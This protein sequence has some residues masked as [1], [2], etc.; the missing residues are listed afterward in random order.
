MACVTKKSQKNRT[1]CHKSTLSRD[2]YSKGAFLEEVV[3]G[4]TSAA[5][6]LSCIVE[7]RI[8]NEAKTIPKQI[9]SMLLTL[10][11]LLT[12]FPTA[13]FAEDTAADRPASA[14]FKIMGLYALRDN[15]RRVSFFSYESRDNA[16]LTKAN[17]TYPD[18]WFKLIYVIERSQ[19]VTLELYE[20]K[21]EPAYMDEDIVS[22]PYAPED[23]ADGHGKL[24]SEGVPWPP[25]R[26]TGGRSGAGKYRPASGGDDIYTAEQVSYS[27]ID[28]DEWLNIVYQ[29]IRGKRQPEVIEDFYA[30][31]L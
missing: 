26:R 21:D 29:T 2:E 27:P 4:A 28:E 31:W 24:Q 1:T 5:D 13:V 23:D 15:G 22:M 12:L 20:M 3:I 7:R 25:T 17:M 9:I 14:E 19:P 11:M 18:S 16:F 8:S 6:P 10:A 30:F